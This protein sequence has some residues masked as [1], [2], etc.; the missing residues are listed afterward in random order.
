MTHPAEKDAGLKM[1]P[2]QWLGALADAWDAGR[3]Q[4]QRD[5]QGVE[6]H[7]HQRQIGLVCHSHGGVTHWH[8]NDGP[9]YTLHAANPYRTTSIPPEGKDS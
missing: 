2:Q 6:E 7:R 3:K 9:A 4:G 1:T 5:A 8:D